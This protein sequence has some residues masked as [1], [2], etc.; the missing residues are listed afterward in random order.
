M[1]KPDFGRIDRRIDWTPERIAYVRYLAEERRMPAKEIATD[2]GLAANQAP[3]IFELCK[4]CMIALSGQAGRRR[5][6]D[7]M[8]FPVTVDGKN[9]A[10]LAQLTSRYG[11]SHG[12][13]AELIVNGVL[14][15]GTV[16]AENI[17]DIWDAG[18]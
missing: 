16:F 3:R 4:R 15:Q 18:A 11:V 8:V 5:T 2:I 14:E 1:L 17:V 6:R 13:V 10:T 12:R 7:A 9:A